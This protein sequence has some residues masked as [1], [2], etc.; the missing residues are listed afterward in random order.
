MVLTDPLQASLYPTLHVPLIECQTE[1][2]D[3]YVVAVG[4]AKPALCPR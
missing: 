2:E 4:M 3:F 1:V